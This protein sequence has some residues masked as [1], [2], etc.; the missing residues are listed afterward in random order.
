[1][2]GRCEHHRPRFRKG[3]LLTEFSANQTSNE[4]QEGSFGCQERAQGV[5]L[6]MVP[7]PTRQSWNGA[8]EKLGE[9]LYLAVAKAQPHGAVDIR[10]ARQVSRDPLPHSTFTEC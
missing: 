4:G 7:F 1:M 2:A 5:L 6:P 10:A 9:K 3:E 8:N